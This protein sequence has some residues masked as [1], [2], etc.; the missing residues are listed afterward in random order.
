MYRISASASAD[1]PH[2]LGIRIRIFS[3]CNI[4]IRI[5]ICTASNIRIRNRIR[6]LRVQMCGYI[7]FPSWEGEREIGAWGRQTTPSPPLTQVPLVKP[8]VGNLR[9]AELFCAV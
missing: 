9:P 4:R 3:A 8:G 5:R 7:F 2:F 6:G 1:Y